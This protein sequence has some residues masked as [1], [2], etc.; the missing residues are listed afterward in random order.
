MRA[1]VLLRLVVGQ[2]PLSHV[3]LVVQMSVQ[4]C[5][6]CSTSQVNIK[7]VIMA[8]E[9]YDDLQN[10]GSDDDAP[11][12]VQ[13]TSAKELAQ[14]A[15]KQELAQQKAQQDA[16]KKKRQVQEAKRAEQKQH[17]QRLKRK[18]AASN[19]ADEQSEEPQPSGRQADGGDGYA[20]EGEEA[21]FLP[22]SV[23]EALQQ[24]GNR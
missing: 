14:E 2:Q 18:A 16:A 5:H 10:T 22:A 23:L 17:S 3:L 21:D 12:E 8:E 11:E 4:A 6:V 15:K 24:D 19:E 13:L 20:L 9:Y 7:P 1:L